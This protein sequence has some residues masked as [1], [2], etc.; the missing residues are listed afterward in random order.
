M[1]YNLSEQKNQ[2]KYMSFPR[3]IIE[4]EHEKKDQ[5]RAKWT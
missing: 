1:Y 5:S 4:T 2:V 3:S